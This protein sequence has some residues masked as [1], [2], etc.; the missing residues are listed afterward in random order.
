MNNAVI[1]SKTLFSIPT[2]GFKN[3]VDL[4]TICFVSSSGT[5]F[6]FNRCK[7]IN[8]RNGF[9][10]ILYEKDVDHIFFTHHLYRLELEQ[11]DIVLKPMRSKCTRLVLPELN[12]RVLYSFFEK[13]CGVNSIREIKLEFESFDDFQ[14]CSLH[15]EDLFL[16]GFGQPSSIG[17]WDQ[18]DLIPAY[19]FAGFSLSADSNS[20]VNDFIEFDVAENLF[21]LA[22]SLQSIGLEDNS[23]D[24]VVER[25]LKGLPCPEDKKQHLRNSWERARV[26]DIYESELDLY[27]R[28]SC[29]FFA[30]YILRGIAPFLDVFPSYLMSPKVF[31]S[32]DCYK[33][34]LF[35]VSPLP[36]KEQVSLT[37]H[38]PRYGDL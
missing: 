19:C 25:L 5:T 13:V 24:G 11:Q 4:S 27:Y 35:R 20:N 22:V 33:D 15:P 17:R 28:S 18:Q 36:E 30:L 21:Y 34:G 2:I 16:L 12:T 38:S 29:P 26:L 1:K 23:F 31:V 3:I 6:R 9:Y 7:L 32:V 10:F 14:E 37:V 8:P